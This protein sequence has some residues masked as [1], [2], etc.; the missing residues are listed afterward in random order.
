MPK[1]IVS[2]WE[3]RIFGKDFASAESAIKKY[4]LGNIKKSEEFYILSR[5]K[6]DNIKIREDVVEVKVLQAINEHGLEQWSPAARQR[7]PISAASLPELFKHIGSIPIT[8]RQNHYT[9]NQ[10]LQE[11]TQ[12][13]KLLKVVKVKKHRNIYVINQCIVEIAEVGFAGIPFK[14]I[15]VEFTDPEIVLRTVRGLGLEQQLNVSYVKAL[16]TLFEPVRSTLFAATVS[17]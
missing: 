17:K 4:P 2:R 15:C 5:L 7:L 11:L 13:S 14:S 6:N 1:T 12:Y 9:R 8:L 3:W 10:L 16:K